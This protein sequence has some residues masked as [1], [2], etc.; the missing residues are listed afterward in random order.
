MSEMQKAETDPSLPATSPEVEFALVLSRVIETMKQDPAQLRQNIY[1]LARMKLRRER[2]SAIR[3]RLTGSSGHSK[4]RSSAW[5]HFRKSRIR[6]LIP[7][8][9]IR[10]SRR[11][12]DMRRPSRIDRSLS[13]A[14]SEEA[15]IGEEATAKR[16]AT[17]RPKGRTAASSKAWFGLGLGIFALILCAAA[18]RYS[19]LWTGFGSA[20]NAPVTAKG[21]HPVAP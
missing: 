17:P 19:G 2:F 11:L 15:G 12:P 3:V 9:P 8:P 1:E 7:S 13:S 10:S 18:L 16:S 20:K 5:R 6:R 14:G 4:P 21:M